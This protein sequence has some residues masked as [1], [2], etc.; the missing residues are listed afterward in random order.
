MRHRRTAAAVALFAL[1]A[2]ADGQD[3]FENPEY[4]SW[5]KFKPGTSLTV[6]VTS[7]VGGKSN[8]TV[9][10]NTLV[11]VAADKLVLETAVTD[12]AG[13][14]EVI[15]PGQK[16]DVPKTVPI[17]PGFKKEDLPGPGRKPPGT[18]EEGTETLKVGGTE[19]KAKWYRIKQTV[20]GGGEIEGKTWM[21]DEVP[22]SVLK[23]ETSVK[24]S[25]PVGTKMEVV[26]VK[27][28]K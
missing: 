3:T 25:M 17:L 23:S 11:S 15:H 8:E 19:Y 16:R 14:K 13:G 4:T 28:G 26:A 2:T 20:P 10:T 5:A 7:T 18:V 1:A 27:K 9:I 12:K 24:G 22:G 21:S 6:K